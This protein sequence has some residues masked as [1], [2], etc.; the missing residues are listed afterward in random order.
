MLILGEADEDR[1]RMRPKEAIA[2]LRSLG[3]PLYVW[4]LGDPAAARGWE[5]VTDISSRPKL[6]GAI[7]S[8]RKQLDAQRILWVDGDYLVSEL[9]VK[10]AVVESLSS[11][12]TAVAG[13][14]HRR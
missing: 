7:A 11:E 6:D 9:N 8:L 4:S 14:S 10:S 12:P 5:E 13:S 2:Y 1:S 3:V